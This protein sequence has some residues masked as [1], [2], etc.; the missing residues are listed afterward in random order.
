MHSPCSSETESDPPRACH[1]STTARRSGG[2]G[3]SAGGGRKGIR[4]KQ[5][6]AVS[7]CAAAM[8]RPVVLYRARTPGERQHVVLAVHRFRKP[9]S[10][11]R[12]PLLSYVALS[13]SGTLSIV[14]TT[15]KHVIK[16]SFTSTLHSV[17]RLRQKN[18]RRCPNRTRTVSTQRSPAGETRA[19]RTYR[20]RNPYRTPSSHRGSY[21]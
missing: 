5:V 18:R 11:F 20:S 17:P 8:E 10:Q 15:L 9:Q 7:T 1:T 4:S 13:K 21:M 19:P 16:R 3:E 2:A 6:P 14:H 12:K